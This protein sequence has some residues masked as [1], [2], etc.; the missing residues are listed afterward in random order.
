M[1]AIRSY[2]ASLDSIVV[3]VESD[4]YTMLE[5]AVNET[6]AKCEE[7]DEYVTSVVSG[8]DREFV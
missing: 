4:D 2:Y 5:K 8:V 1:Y 6:T 7:L 3:L